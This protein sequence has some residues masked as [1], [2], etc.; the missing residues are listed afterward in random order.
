MWVEIVT[1]T[2]TFSNITADEQR[3]KVFENKDREC[4]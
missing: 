3:G 1:F 4:M 2:A